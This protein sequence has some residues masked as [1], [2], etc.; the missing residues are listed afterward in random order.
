MFSKHIS[1]FYPL[2]W[3]VFLGLGAVSLRTGSQEQTFLNWPLWLGLCVLG[4]LIIVLW[5]MVF[6]PNDMSL[7]PYA[8]GLVCCVAWGLWFVI[9]LF[10]MAVQGVDFWPSMEALLLLNALIVGLASI[11]FLGFLMLEGG[12]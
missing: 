2:S 3:V 5:T 10:G 1:F 6:E 4:T 7:G 9:S 8:S 12:V 11:F